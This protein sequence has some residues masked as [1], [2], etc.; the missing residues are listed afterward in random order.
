MLVLCYPNGALGH[1]FSALLDYCTVE[2]GA[3][4]YPIFINGKNLHQHKQKSHFYK[5]SHPTVICNND[6]TL[7]SSTSNSDFGKL[8]ILLMS[9]AKHSKKIPDF[10]NPLML[11]QGSGSFGKQV[12]ILSLTIRDKLEKRND[13]FLNSD[14]IFDILWYWENVEDIVI[15]LKKLNL[16]PIE[17]KVIE[18]ANM[19]AT[20]NQM[21]Y[22]N[23]K[24]CF[25]LVDDIVSSRDINLDLSF[26]DTTLVHMLLLKHI[27]AF[28]YR[29]IKLLVHS[30]KS[31]QDFI[32]IIKEKHYG[33]TI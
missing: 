1:C 29:Q 25:E 8:L 31:T 33:K 20:S 15:F 13:W 21:Y 27:K 17:N 12:E 30:P 10:N 5:I 6:D 19:V 24:H 9:L 28:D 4:N 14:N 26:F 11:K 2:G 16:T 32:N 18:F 3:E 7:I 22:N 23:I